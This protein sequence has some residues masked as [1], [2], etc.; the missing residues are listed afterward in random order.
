MNLDKRYA[1]ALNIFTEPYKKDKNVIG[2]ILSGST[3]NAKPDKNSDLDVFMVTKESKTR[4]RGNTWVNG[5]E[6]EYFI[7]PVKQIE[8]YFK[9]E[10]KMKRN[11][12]AHIFS[13]SVV[14]FE[15]GKELGRLIKE[16]KK[17]MGRKN[18]KMDRVVRENTRYQ[19]DDLEKDLE[20][21]I[22][23]KDYFAFNVIATK[24][25]E[26][27]LSAFFALHRTF[28]AKTKRLLSQ[29]QSLDADFAVLYEKAIVERDV[30]LRH[31]NILELIRYIEA[32][33][34]GKR[35]RE[36]KLT[37]KCTYA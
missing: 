7:N 24:L 4:T 35:P 5:I 25:L 3:V 31:Q 12:T 27:I 10:L 20:D 1:D 6:I 19:I 23:R 15:R 33:L 34:G 18:N 22:L 26:N 36:W 30:N 32:K 17:I 8:F 29:L 11:V 9:D 28:T 2:I 37:T 16:A 13:N 14:L 21:V